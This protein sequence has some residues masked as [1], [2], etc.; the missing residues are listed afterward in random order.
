MSSLNQLRPIPSLIGVGLTFFMTFNLSVSMYGCDQGKQQVKQSEAPAQMSIEAKANVLIT[1]AWSEESTVTPL[2]KE[3]ATR[4]K[5]Q[6]R[7]L[8]HRL[9]THSSTIRKL[10][11]ILSENPTLTPNDATINDA[12]RYTIEVRDEPPGNYVQTIHEVLKHLE[13]K[14]HTVLK[15]KNTWPKGDN[16]SGVNTAL[17]TPKDT[18]WELHFHTPES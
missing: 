2:L 4:F 16:Y 7:G 1:Q 11:K 14:G 12:L 15:V 17:Q 6:L 18:L 8:E 13:S 10:K 5:G 9:K 3:L